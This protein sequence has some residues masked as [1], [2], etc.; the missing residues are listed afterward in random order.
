[1]LTPEGGNYFGGVAYCTRDAPHSF[2]AAQSFVCTGGV[3]DRIPRYSLAC[4][5]RP[6]DVHGVPSGGDGK[7]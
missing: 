7:H 6:V 3:K 4:R 1:M 5:A 2:V